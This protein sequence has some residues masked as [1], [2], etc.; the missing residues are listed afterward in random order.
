MDG[1]AAGSC[2]TKDSSTKRSA[3][4]LAEEDTQKEKVQ[5]AESSSRK[6]ERAQSIRLEIFSPIF[7]K[8]L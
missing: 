5:I 3:A 7:L 8:N 6:K 2:D 4:P 1:D